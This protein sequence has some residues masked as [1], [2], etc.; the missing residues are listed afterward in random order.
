MFLFTLRRTQIRIHFLFVACITVFLLTDPTGIAVLGLTASLLHESGHLL[1]M[2]LMGYRPELISFEINGIRLEKNMVGIPPFQEFLLLISGSLVNGIIAL[3]RIF[4]T[5]GNL[6]FYSVIH[7]FIG[8]LNLLPLSS[9]D[10]GKLLM[11]FLRCFFP[12][13][14]QQKVFDGI[15]ILFLSIL[16]YICFLCFQNQSGNLTL[17]ILCGYASITFCMEWMENRE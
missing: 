4:F 2:A 15:Q 11:L 16:G 10:G 13:Y 14:W 5:Q 8:G 1:A 3:L 17:L 9:L 7:L 6:P 12:S